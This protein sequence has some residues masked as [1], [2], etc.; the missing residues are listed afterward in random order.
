MKR[1]RNAARQAQIQDFFEA[2]NQ[3]DKDAE[4]A[5]YRPLPPD[6]YIFDEQSKLCFG[7]VDWRFFAFAAPETTG[8]SSMHGKSDAGGRAG[9]R[10][11]S[12]H[13]RRYRLYGGNYS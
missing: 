10:L 11:T 9:I 8:D 7:A 6:S 3:H 12:S 4:A 2:R 1:C 13:K 5:P